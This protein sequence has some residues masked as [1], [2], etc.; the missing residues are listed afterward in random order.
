[1][2]LGAAYCDEL[3][4]IA[5]ELTTTYSERVQDRTMARG[6]ERELVAHGYDPRGIVS[7]GEVQV[8]HDRYRKKRAKGFLPSHK[9][10]YVHD[11]VKDRSRAKRYGKQRVAEGYTAAKSDSHLY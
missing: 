4:K 2:D 10:E 3:Y 1:M 6:F 11:E 8:K 7:P 5:A 9:A